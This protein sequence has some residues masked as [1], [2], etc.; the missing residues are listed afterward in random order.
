MILELLLV[1]PALQL[2]G[3][4]HNAAP[5]E[6]RALVGPAT[7]PGS[8][9]NYTWERLTPGN[10]GI[11]GDYVHKIF[12]DEN[13]EPWIPAYI[14]FWEHGGIAHFDGQHWNTISNVDYPVIKSPRFNDI[15]A[16]GAGVM[17]IA[18]D[19]GLLRFD[20]KVGPV[21]LKRFDKANSPLPGNQ[22]VDL[23]FDPQGRLWIASQELGGST[24]G[25]LVRYDP[26]GDQWTVWN[27]SGGLP[28]SQQWPGWH[29]V[30]RVAV[31]PDAGGGFTV[32]FHGAVGMATWKAGDFTY[33]APGS[34][35]PSTLM[36]NDP[37]DPEGNVWMMTSGGLARRAPDGTFTVTGFPPGL[38]TEVSVVAGISGGRGLLGTYY[39]DVWVWDGGWSYHSNWA[40]PFV[41]AGSHTYTLREDSQGD[42]WAGGIGGAAK[43][44]DGAWQRYRMTNTG[45]L[46]Y[47]M[48]EIA[49]APNGDVLMN[50]NAGPGVGGFQIYD[51]RDWTCINDYNYGLGPVWGLPS[52]ETDALWV[53]ENGD[54]AVAP[55]GL[56]GIFDWDGA[57]F[58]NLIPQGYS[59]I[60]AAEDGLGRLWAVRDYGYGVFLIEANGQYTEFYP[61]NSPLF[62]GDI[63][64][65]LVDPEPGYVWLVCAFGAIRTDG[66]N[67]SVYPRELLGL[68]LNSLGYHFTCGALADDG[69]LWLGTGVGLYHFDP[70]TGAYDVR[71]PANS[72]LP[73]D[74][75]DNV[76]LAP[77]GTVWCTTFDNVWPY[78]GGLTHFEGASSETFRAEDSPLPH[79]QT[80]ALEIRPKPGGLDGYEVWIGSASEGVT[81]LRTKPKLQQKP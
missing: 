25:G 33:P 17:W 14:P 6:P 1:A 55:S 5:I 26:L 31:A 24:A 11:P 43:F 74:D 4:G 54:V 67:W 3:P 48:E 9:G 15:V 12:L 61:G 63:P 62:G 41:G 78:P 71:T 60:D 38:S 10:T 68:T 8:T 27:A 34:P 52:D 45:M 40:G 58:T 22:L 7:G 53:R 39:S 50:G 47:F 51:G 13:D 44:E 20:P 72:T 79:N 32:W 29:W 35:A 76:A 66:V 49:F 16:D 28:W 21:S 30:D 80:R 65:V 75:I 46:G 77:D 73:S 64:Q 23:D 19:I 37:V 81:V 57:S 18:T 70:A 69:T 2:A 59:I 36:S 42:L 56:Q